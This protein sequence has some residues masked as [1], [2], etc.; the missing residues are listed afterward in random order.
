MRERI[1]DLLAAVTMRYSSST[2]INFYEGF[3]NLVENGVS[4][5]DALKDLNL[6]WSDGG[7]K[8]N[9]PLAIFSRD[10]M[11][12]LVDGMPLSQALTRWVPYEEASLI[13]AGSRGAGLSQAC[14]DVVRVIDAQQQI[15]G[16]LASAVMYPSFL[17]LP[18]GTLL[19]MVSDQMVP[20]MAKVSDPAKWTG[21]SGALYLVSNLTTNYGVL[22]ICGLFLLAIAFI[23]SL[24][25]WT[26]ALRAAVDNGPFY[27]TY[28]MVHGSVFL[29]NLAV[30]MRAGS[31]PNEALKTLAEY[32]NPWLK[33]RIAG[34][35]HGLDKG[36]NLGVALENSGFNFP[37]KKAIQFIRILAGR[38][39]F[40]EAINKYAARWLASS[41]KK[42]QLLAKVSFAVGMLVIGVVMGLIVTGTQD[43]QNNF[44]RASVRASK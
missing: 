16:A 33:E 43:M 23:V 24:P 42:L 22:F 8:P 15:R 20:V 2:R 19:W 38:D 21:S 7:K 39:G 14:D 3:Q 44:E 17:A 11:I 10:L 36:D 35:R 27:A 32:A 40:P 12:H 13:A 25:R 29:L 4:P 41:I 9:E 34:A 30:M 1:Y 31:G 37:D 5:N 6:I 26:G 18:L 28:R